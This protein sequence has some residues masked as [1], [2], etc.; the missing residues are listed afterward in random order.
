LRDRGGWSA[1]QQNQED[2]Q[3]VIVRIEFAHHFSDSKRV[4]MPTQAR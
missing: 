3:K 4:S 1:E 2:A